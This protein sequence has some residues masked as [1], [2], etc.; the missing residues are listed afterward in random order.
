MS[1]T[2]S[3]SWLTA[4]ESLRTKA[5]EGRLDLPADRKLHRSFAAAADDYIKRLEESGGKNLT[6]KRMHLK[7]HL[8]PYFGKLR[9]DRLSEFQ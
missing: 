7:L 6:A 3:T 5:R 8:K 4:I 1:A 9:V 2:A